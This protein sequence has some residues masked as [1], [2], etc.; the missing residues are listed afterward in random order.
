MR[1]ALLGLALILAAPASAE[2]L[3]VTANGFEVRHRIA[4]VKPGERVVLTG[5][6]G[7]LLFEAASG[8]MDV[9]VERIAGGSRLTLDSRAA[10]FA[11]GNAAIFG[12]AVDQ[13]LGEQV[14]RLRTYAAAQGTKR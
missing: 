1:I 7:P 5:A 14:K 6:L 11:K 13:M 10:G 12:P 8:V 4:L 3:S 9:R 2:V